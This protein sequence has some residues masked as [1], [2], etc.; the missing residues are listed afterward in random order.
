MSQ[1]KV[2]SKFCPNCRAPLN[3]KEAFKRIYG[4][5]RLKSKRKSSKTKKG[6]RKTSKRKSKRNNKYKKYKKNI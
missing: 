3:E 4:G 2:F 6:K 5:K 1:D